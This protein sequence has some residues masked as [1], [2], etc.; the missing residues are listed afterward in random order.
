MQHEL[1]FYCSVNEGRA[2]IYEILQTSFYRDYE[3]PSFQKKTPFIDANLLKSITSHCLDVEY[4]VFRNALCRITIAVHNE[5]NYS[6][7]GGICTPRLI[8]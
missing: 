8:G 6:V 1:V 7:K 3:S 2:S 5:L 4:I